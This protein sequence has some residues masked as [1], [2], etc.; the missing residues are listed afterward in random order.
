LR[1]SMAKPVTVASPPSP[2]SAPRRISAS[3][4]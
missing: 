2:I 1:W 4:C 3:N